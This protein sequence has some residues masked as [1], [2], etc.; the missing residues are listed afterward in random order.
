MNKKI[1]EN[2]QTWLGSTQFALLTFSIIW[3]FH[4]TVNSYYYFNQTKSIFV[5]VVLL[6]IYFLP[7]SLMIAELGT[8]FK[9]SEGGVSSWIE[10]TI[11][12]KLG[13]LCGW[14]I[15]SNNLIYLSQKPMQIIV[16][17]NWLF[18][19]SDDVSHIDP[20]IVQLIGVF[21]FLICLFL[22]SKGIK[23]IKNV[24]IVAG[25][26]LFI[27]SILFI[28]LGMI[29][30]LFAEANFVRTFDINTNPELFFPTDFDWIMSISIIIFGLTGM[31][32]SAP[33]ILRMKN[34][35]KDFPKGIIIV[36]MMIIFCAV[37]G[38]LSMSI[39]FGQHGELM[40][41]DFL[42][43]GQ[44]YAFRTLGQY[45]GIGNFFL[46]IYSITML[47]ATISA[48][49]INIDLPN[50]IFVGNADKEFFPEF[51]LKKNKNGAYSFWLKVVG[52]I[53]VILQIIPCLGIENTDSLYKWLIDIN[54]ICSPIYVLFI[55]IAYIKLKSSKTHL[56]TRQ[57]NFVFLQNRK[58]AITLASICFITTL[59]GLCTKIYNEDPFIFTMNCV[60]PIIL[61]AMSVIVPIISKIYNKKD[62][63]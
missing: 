26:S 58:L 39:M 35:N 25:T 42:T 5:W 47:I 17:I 49:I 1:K 11:G 46:I 8:Y 7:S 6:L 59:I 52:I 54:S 50:R 57:N 21:I 13:Y 30:P 63:K 41:N 23:L 31:D 18:F 38:I 45:F 2:K 43:N 9:D 3:G 22:A 55:F 33:Y 19:Q 14:I 27:L 12:P 34:P 60:L 61:L 28:V 40:N 29:G 4:N 32:R 62:S 15:W 44:F 56:S 16:A 51:T 53:V 10:N 24:A 48:L 36:S 37:F 20:V